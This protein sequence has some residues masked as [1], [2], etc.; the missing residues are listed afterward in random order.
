MVE[1]ALLAALPSVV[2]TADAAR[3]RLR[4]A[5]MAET[6]EVHEEEGD[7]Q[8][9]P[10]REDREPQR[11]RT[12]VFV[13]SPERLRLQQRRKRRSPVLPSLEE[14]PAA[15][16]TAW[17]AVATAKA[18]VDADEE[19]HAKAAAVAVT[20]AQAQA[21]A[22]AEARAEAQAHARA[23][24]LSGSRLMVPAWPQQ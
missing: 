18:A 14:E 15:K 23:P 16:A 4:F 8:R 10:V 11:T 20:Q 5:A 13:E 2:E 19:A 12:S 9:R 1:R 17:R 6:D 21:Q 22:R 7:E 24:S 3:S